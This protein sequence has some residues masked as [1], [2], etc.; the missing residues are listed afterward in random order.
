MKNK[1]NTSIFYLKKKE[2]KVL[3]WSYVAGIG[4]GGRRGGCLVL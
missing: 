2:K 1:E 3:I 4:G